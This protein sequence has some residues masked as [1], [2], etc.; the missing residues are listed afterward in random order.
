MFVCPGQCPS[1]GPAQSCRVYV[2][3]CLISSVLMPSKPSASHQIWQSCHLQFKLSASACLSG[4]CGLKS[5]LCTGR[6][7]KHCNSGGLTQS[8]HNSNTC[9]EWWKFRQFRELTQFQ[10]DEIQFQYHLMLMWCFEQ[11]HSNVKALG[12][13]KNSQCK[14]M[15]AILT[16]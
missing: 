2:C 8:W 10:L 7:W 3:L 13:R 4:S 15:H 5:P 1:W 6:V 11:R 14:F 9:F 12:Q 16:N